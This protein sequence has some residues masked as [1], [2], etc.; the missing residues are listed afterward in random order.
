MLLSRP[1]PEGVISYFAQD[2]TF[3]LDRPAELDRLDLDRVGTFGIS[4]GGTVGAQACRQDIRLKAGLAMDVEQ[5]ADVTRTGLRQPVLFVTCDADT[6]RLERVRSGGWSERDIVRTLDTMRATY[7]RSPQAYYVQVPDIRG[8]ATLGQRMRSGPGRR[9]PRARGGIAVPACPLSTIAACARPALIDHRRRRRT[10]D[11]GAAGAAELT[12]CSAQ[13]PMSAG[14]R[15]S[16]IARPPGWPTAMRGAPQA[17]HSDGWSWREVTSRSRLSQTITR[18]VLSAVA[19]QAP[20]R[21]QETECTVP[22]W[23]VSTTATGC[24]A[25]GFHRRRVRSSPVLA[26]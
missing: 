17:R 9:R 18:P 6:M 12:E 10:D 24:P 25:A 22:W 16:R 8:A 1:L 23:C 20:S 11:Q 4:T 13:W 21:D 26:R 2:V 15:S 7:E 14:S 3:T 5:T 19:R